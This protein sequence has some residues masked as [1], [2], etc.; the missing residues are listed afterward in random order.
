[1]SFTRSE[2][3]TTEDTLRVDGEKVPVE[4]AWQDK[5]ADALGNSQTG[6]TAAALWQHRLLLDAFF[7]VMAQPKSYQIS[8]SEGR[9]TMHRGRPVR[10]YA[11]S[12]I[13]IDLTEAKEFRRHYLTG[14]RSSPRLHQVR[15]HFRHYGGER[16]CIHDWVPVEG[17]EKRWTCA[18]C[19]RRR[20]ALGPFERGDANK[21]FVYQSYEITA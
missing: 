21:G 16:G 7:L 12:V 11:R 5:L 18:G 14:S 3:E 15:R 4:E 2:S 10:Y 1:M 6:Q 19:G 17:Q 13:K 8:F 20:V 9:R